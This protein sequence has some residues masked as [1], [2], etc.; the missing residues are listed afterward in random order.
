MELKPYPF[1]GGEVKITYRSLQTYTTNQ[2]MQEIRC[3]WEIGCIA[4][5]FRREKTAAYFLTDDESF[6]TVIDGRRKLIELWNR[7]DSNG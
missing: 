5:G 1:C 2:L 4:C 7:R 6:L 3:V